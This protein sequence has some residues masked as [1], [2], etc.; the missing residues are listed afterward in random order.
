MSAKKKTTPTTATPA[1]KPAQPDMSLALTEPLNGV[2]RQKM[3]KVGDT[4]RAMAARVAKALV[5]HEAT[6]AIPGVSSAAMLED[7]RVSEK[8]IPSEALAQR[9]LV[10]LGN[11]RLVR[12]D[13]TWRAVVKLHRR[14]QNEGSDD[15]E[16]QSDF[17][18]LMDY[19]AKRSLKVEERPRKAK[20]AK[21]PKAPAPAKTPDTAKA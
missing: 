13:R 8:I 7:I 6:L 16:V 10:L 2:A 14:L 11:A 18:F 19:M 1:K 20:A 17:Q 21:A 3:L 9:Q 4:D 5:K 12:D 15:P